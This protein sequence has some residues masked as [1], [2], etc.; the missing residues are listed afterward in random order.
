MPRAKTNEEFYKEVNDVNP[1]IDLYGFYKNGNSKIACK[2]KKC[3]YKWISTAR[4]LLK[5]KKCLGCFHTEKIFEYPDISHEEFCEIIS[6]NYPSLIIT[7]T[8]YKGL[9]L[10]S[11]TCKDCDY[12]SRIRVQM[13]LEKTYKCP[14]CKDGKENIKYG[15]NDIKKIITS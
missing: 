6:K 4:N 1:D 10:I 8:Y 7:G 3:G 15:I 11:C 9:K 13:L 14:I 12:H 5:P 2:C